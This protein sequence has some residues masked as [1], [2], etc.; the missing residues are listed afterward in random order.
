MSAANRRPADPPDLPPG[1]GRRRF[2]ARAVLLWEQVWPALFPALC[3]LGVALLLALSGVAAHLP[4]WG[5]ALTLSVLA[6]AFLVLL[7]RGLRRCRIPDRAAADRRLERDS[8]LRHRP[9]QGLADRPVAQGVGLDFWQVHIGRLREQVR[10]L[11]LSWPRAGLVAAD[12]YAIRAALLVALVAAFVMTGH[13]APRLLRQ[14]LWPQGAARADIA[15][16]EAWVTP[17]AYTG[18]APL[19][20]DTAGGD[21]S[22]PEGSRL[23]IS[24]TGVTATPALWVG[25]RQAELRRLDA[26]SFAAEQTLTES[27]T[28]RVTV[29]GQATAV[30]RV[31][32]QADTP[33]RVAFTAP[34]GR[35]ERDL[36]LRLPWHAEDDWG[37]TALTVELRLREKPDAAPLVIPVPLPVGETRNIGETLWVDLT[38]HPWAGLEVTA[39]LRAHDGREQEGLSDE[40]QFKL[41]ERMFTHPVARALI[42][43]RRALAVS[44][45]RRAAMLRLDEVNL[46][47]AAYGD[48]IVVYLGVVAARARLQ[49]DRRRSA[50]AGEVQALLWE[51]ALRVEEGVST[52]TAQALEDAR[53]HLQDALHA[54]LNRDAAPGEDEEGATAEPQADPEQALRELR[55]A[56]ARHMEALRRENTR[57]D[58]AL[59]EAARREMNRLLDGVR[60]SLQENRPGDAGR[61]MAEL[62]E[63]LDRLLQRQRGSPDQQRNAE[64]R[65]RGENQ[66]SVMEDLVQ[67]EAALMDNSRMRDAAAQM[68]ALP[69]PEQAPAARPADRAVDLRQQQALRRAL[70]EVMQQYGDLT[71]DIPQGLSV[72]DRAMVAAAEALAARRD[73]A[74]RNAQ[75]RA[76]EALLQSSREMSRQM[77]SQFGEGG[78]QGEAQAMRGGGRMPRNRGEGDRDPLGRSM[79]EAD[80]PGDETAL[81][82]RPERQRVRDIQEELRRRGADRSR[83]ATEL[84]YIDRLLKRF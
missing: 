44:A 47:P 77:A 26:A 2:L 46:A 9:L 6:A 12:P 22:A 15:V 13:E 34:P 75:R 83:P 7:L 38:E 61:Q 50:A 73:E 24:M 16:L 10:H 72:A 36:R 59:D 11:R 60:Q 37:V 65:Q 64:R 21:V 42:D 32:V 45:D 51:L 23:S 39:R 8:G 28:L 33:P 58:P 54:Y 62:D 25:T 66:M 29:H 81:P 30:W 35:G 76:L 40:A 57:Q 52:R 55:G 84:E 4:V 53:A 82:D 69:R 3:V 17:P 78:Q 79:G 20:L 70:G 80:D 1:L 14:A 56:I 41:P 48:D 43:I 71:G 19:L 27:T 67:R 5:H 18:R 49:R 68:P 74:A 63:L 31:A